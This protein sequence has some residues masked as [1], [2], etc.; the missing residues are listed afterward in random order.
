[1][2]VNSALALAAVLVA[3]C[4]GSGRAPDP[5]PGQVRTTL[6]Q[7]LAA[8]AGGDYARACTLMT[9]DTQAATVRATRDRHVSDCPGALRLVWTSAPAAQRDALAH[10]TIRSVTVTGLTAAV[11]M[12]KTAKPTYL[13]KVAGRWLVDA[14]R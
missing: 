6:R 11:S 13:R 5:A 14:R 7:F 10:D 4:G 2:G 3:G 12:A 9:A 8:F 1:M